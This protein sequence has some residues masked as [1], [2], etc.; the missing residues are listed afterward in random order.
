MKKLLILL[1]TFSLIS[2]S[3]DNP[4]ETHEFRD[5]LIGYYK[6]QSVYSDEAIDLNGDGI[7]QNNLMIEAE[8]QNSFFEYFYGEFTYNSS[9]NKSEF[10]IDVPY[11]YY[12]VFLESQTTCIE[13]TGLFN[14]VTI[15]EQT[16]EI[17]II[18]AD[19]YE[20]WEAENGSIT[21]IMWENGLI[22]FIVI[23]ELYTT[24]GWQ[25]VNIHLI[26]N[27]WIPNSD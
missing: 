26:Y 7:A 5:S 16:Q 9:A 14:N 27:K 21:H 25:Q 18:E 22:H 3:N 11:S 12:S 20:E 23:K 2:C 19:R 1:A 15:N 8:C 13:K 10:S 6:L 24:E 4:Q 17:T